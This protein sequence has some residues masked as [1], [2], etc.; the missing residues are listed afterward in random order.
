LD[1]FLIRMVWPRQ[2]YWKGAKLYQLQIAWPGTL[3]APS[4]SGFTLI[5]LHDNNFVLPK[6]IK[7]CFFIL[8]QSAFSHRGAKRHPASNWVSFHA[9]CPVR[10]L[11]T[12]QFIAF[13]VPSNA[14][15]PLTILFLM[16]IHFLCHVL[17]HTGRAEFLQKCL[18]RQELSVIELNT[19]LR[20][21]YCRESLP[22]TVIVFGLVKCCWAWKSNP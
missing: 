4:N 14:D 12:Y 10:V 11:T 8:L 3:L 16:P 9:V 13:F 22:C 19:A 7:D 15:K 5:S 18:C 21:H 17:L 20:W 2:N 1:S 6:S